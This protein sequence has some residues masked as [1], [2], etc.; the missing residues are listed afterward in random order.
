[1]EILTYKTCIKCG[2]VKLKVDFPH[3]STKDAGRKNSCKACNSRL[4]KIRNKL[5]K[6]NHK[7]RCNTC[8]ICERTDRKLVLDHDHETDEFRGYLCNNCNSA[9]GRFDDDIEVLQKAI[10]YLRKTND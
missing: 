7:P 8:A 10:N 9:L 1:M 3:F 5:R 6:V 4:A 2:E